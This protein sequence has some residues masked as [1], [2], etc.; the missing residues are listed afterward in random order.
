MLRNDFITHLSRA[1]NDSVVVDINGFLIDVEGVKT[2]RGSVVVV[3]N[4]E[5]LRETLQ[6]IAD[7]RMPLQQPPT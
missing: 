1:D 5:D 7:G 4:E 3:L 6:K 2:E